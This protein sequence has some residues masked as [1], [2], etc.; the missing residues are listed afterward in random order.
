LLQEI[1]TS[2]DQLSRGAK[3]THNKLE[4]IN[5]AFISRSSA[6]SQCGMHTEV[7]HA[8]ST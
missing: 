6:T 4:P 2:E 1:K 5:A 3:V 8:Y 7:W